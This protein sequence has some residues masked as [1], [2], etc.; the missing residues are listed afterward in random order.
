MGVSCEAAAALLLGERGALTFLTEN[1]EELTLGGVLRL[2]GCALPEERLRF[3]PTVD[4]AYY[5]ALLDRCARCEAI[6]EAW[7]AALAAL[8]AAKDLTDA[9]E[10]YINEYDRAA[11]DRVFGYI[12][13]RQL[14]HLPEYGA[15][16][17]LRCAREAADFIFL[18]DARERDTAE[19]LRR[20]SAE[21]EYSDEN[22]LRLLGG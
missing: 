10:V 8:R 20:W 19:C 4:A 14:E 7:T 16:R 17:L 22:M 18:W 5:R 13:Y 3:A 9:A 15:E 11:Y 2:L 6:D 12:L 21:M 1:G